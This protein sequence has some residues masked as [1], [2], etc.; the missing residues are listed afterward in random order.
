MF[1]VAVEEEEELEGRDS[2][3]CG[4]RFSAPS[5]Q[6]LQHLL[7]LSGNHTVCYCSRQRPKKSR[8][9]AETGGGGEKEEQIAE[10]DT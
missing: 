7:P 1:F 8:G 9:E 6:Q 2:E 5:G 3:S 4:G 10:N